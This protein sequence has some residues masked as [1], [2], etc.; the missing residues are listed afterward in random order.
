[1]FIVSKSYIGDD[2]SPATRI[3]CGE[4]IP[5]ATVIRPCALSPVVLGPIKRAI[6]AEVALDYY[7]T[8]RIN[9]FHTDYDFLSLRYVP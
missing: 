6:G 3:R 9:D 7:D 1:M 4:V 5:L 8:F 2:R